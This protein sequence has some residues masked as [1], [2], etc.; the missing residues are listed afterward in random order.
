MSNDAAH[1]MHGIYG[2]YG[3][4]VSFPMISVGSEQLRAIISAVSSDHPLNTG[5][6]T[7]L[8]VED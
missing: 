2:M 1:G 5:P 3:A 4:Y 8:T 7:A 6:F